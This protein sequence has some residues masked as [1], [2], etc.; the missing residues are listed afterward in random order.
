MLRRT[1]ADGLVGGLGDVNGAAVG[2]EAAK[3]IV[4]A[5]DALTLAGTQGFFNHLKLDRLLELAEAR[6]LP[7]LLCCEGGGGR[8]GDTDADLILSSQLR[9]S[10]WVRR[11]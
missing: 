5:Y 4:A 6:R 3:T 10:T 9:V 11:G 7:V 8:P 1:P 2:R